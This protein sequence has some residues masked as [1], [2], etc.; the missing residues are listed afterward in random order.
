MTPTLLLKFSK[1]DSEVSRILRDVTV[2]SQNNLLLDITRLQAMHSQKIFR[3]PH[4]LD[5][6]CCEKCLKFVFL[7]LLLWRYGEKGKAIP[8][9]GRG[10]P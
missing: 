8:V 1:L 10:G 7:V 3:I 4:V 9:T 5:N 2:V 6:K